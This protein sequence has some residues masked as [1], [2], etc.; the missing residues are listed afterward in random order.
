MRRTDASS[1]FKALMQREPER[2]L[3][4][5]TT[6]ASVTQRRLIT[7][8]EGTLTA[9]ATAAPGVEVIAVLPIPGQQRAAGRR[10]T[11]APR[12]P[13]GYVQRRESSES[14]RQS[15][16]FVDKN[17]AVAGGFGSPVGKDLA[18]G[19]AKVVPAAR[20]RG[21]ADP[22]DPAGPAWVAFSRRRYTTSA[23]ESWSPTTIPGRH[24]QNPISPSTA[25]TNSSSCF[26]LNP[27][28]RP[29]AT[30][31]PSVMCGQESTSR[32]WGEAVLLSTDM[33]G[34]VTIWGPIRH[35]MHKPRLH[36]LKSKCQGSN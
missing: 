5:M 24:H 21:L 36:N 1:V 2:A 26:S 8:A 25:S 20:H 28:M 14:S 12:F 4:L 23:T 11:G 15:K 19:S 30:A 10:T 6:Q 16:G 13:F 9:E 7:L 34:S 33:H 3:R 29:Y 35:P 27:V 18:D 22:E 32:Y 31:S 17:G